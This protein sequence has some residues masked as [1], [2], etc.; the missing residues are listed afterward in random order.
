M[1][2][3]AYPLMLGPGGQPAL[4]LYVDN[5]QHAQPAVDCGIPY[6]IRGLNDH[7]GHTA[8]RH[9][10]AVRLPACPQIA[11]TGSRRT[12]AVT[13]NRWHQGRRLPAVRGR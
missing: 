11:G 1:V 10:H 8:E 2:E 3:Y 7:V 13:A 5:Q 4:A 9:C 12:R 6:F